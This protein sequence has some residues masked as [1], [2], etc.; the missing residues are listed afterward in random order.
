[1]FPMVDDHIRM[2]MHDMN[3]EYY[4]PPV[5]ELEDDE[6]EEGPGDENPPE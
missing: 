6:Y 4:L 1:M 2:Y 5:P 3:N